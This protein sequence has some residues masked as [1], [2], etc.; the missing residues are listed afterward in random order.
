MGK[1][2]VA[3]SVAARSGASDRSIADGIVGAT[4]T[5]RL[6]SQ[7]DFLRGV[8]KLLKKHGRVPRVPRVLVT[9]K[10]TSY[11]AANRISV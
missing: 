11:A 10:L 1:R 3:A 8:R 9:D 7:G 4:G 6:T 2:D 5:R